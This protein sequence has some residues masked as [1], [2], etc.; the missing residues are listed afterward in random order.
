MKTPPNF[1]Y[2]TY[3]LMLLY[4]YLGQAQFVF[5]DQKVEHLSLHPYASIYKDE[6]GKMTVEQIRQLDSKLFTPLIVENTD[7]GFTT[8]TYWVKFSLRNNRETPVNYYLESS[9]PIVDHANLFEFRGKQ[10]IQKQLSGDDIPVN[11]KS[12]KQRKTLFNIELNPG[13]QRDYYIQLISDGEVINAPVLLHTANDLMDE[14]SF[15]QVVFG[16]FYGLLLLSTIIYLFFYFAMKERVFLNYSLYVFFIGM[17]QF[18]L[19]GFFHQSFDPNA[20]WFSDKAV[21]FN[22]IIA[23]YFLGA[24]AQHYLKVWEISKRLNRLYYVLYAFLGILMVITVFLP[25]LFHLTYPLMN[26][27]GLF[28]L[29]LIIASLI[30]I[31]MRTQ[32]IYQFFSLGIISL[33]TGFIMFILKNL[34]VLPVSFITENSSKLGTGVEVM[35]LSLSMA[36]LIKQLRDDREKLQGEA[37]QKAE[38]MNEMK[39]YFLSNI[40]HEL[41]TPLNAIINYTDSIIGEVQMSSVL[42]KCEII[43][44]NSRGLLG[45]VNDILDFSKIE[46]GEIQLERQNFQ[47]KKVLE[48]VVTEIKSRSEQKGLDFQFVVEGDL[49]HLVFGDA[50]RIRQILQNVLG[51]AVKFTAEGII[52][53]IVSAESANNLTSLKFTISDSGEGIPKDKMDQ[54]FES[55]TQQQIDNK[56]KYGGL[57]LGL[58]IVKA[59]VNLHNGTLDL[60]SMEN[61]GTVCTIAFNLDVVEMK[62]PIVQE[63]VAP[64]YDLKG[65][66]ILVV[67]D[68]VMNQMVLKMIFKKWQNLEVDFANHGE[69]ALQFMGE[70]NYNLILMDLQMPVMDGYETTIAIR[71]GKS[72]VNESDIPIVAV[73]ADVMETTKERVKEIGMN[74]YMTKP[75]DKEML[76]QIVSAMAS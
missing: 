38:E 45:S 16:F 76:Y 60:N 18:S 31:Y 53:F 49:P 4:S 59:L 19:D 61:Q 68:N 67:E 51:N 23:G 47:I 40:S 73:T 26:V 9:R 1:R 72:G 28:E 50:Q 62:A 70:K 54:I 20:G 2:L 71:E 75:V 12:V 46:K 11:Q 69:E 7:L 14:T 22:A 3:L 30:I 24:Y 32:V 37:L 39:T 57:G 8:S 15:E 35:F 74:H 10:L 6:S 41:R 55:F 66:R 34:S 33:V 36:N 13:E 63:P 58:Y 5:N 42:E 48:D 43:S 17:L 21:I 25:D 44:S 29:L 27:A 65:K 56:R 52:K 64:S